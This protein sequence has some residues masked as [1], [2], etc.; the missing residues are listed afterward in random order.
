MLK[1]SF[2]PNKYRPWI[3]AREK[4]RLSHSHIQ[5]ARELGLNPK[6]FGGL[7]R[8]KQKPWKLP[9]PEFIEKIYFKHFKKNAPD[10]VKSIEQFVKEKAR[11]K[12]EKK[13]RKETKNVTDVSANT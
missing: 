3:E 13:V 6:K 7:G 8:T 4:Y 11:K 12:V 1:K 5:M 10:N 2:V 9:L